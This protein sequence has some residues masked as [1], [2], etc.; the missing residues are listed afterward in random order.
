MK[1]ILAFQCKIKRILPLEILCVT[2][3]AAFF[4]V[5]HTFHTGLSLRTVNEDY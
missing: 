5:K 2:T 4:V 3:T 1:K